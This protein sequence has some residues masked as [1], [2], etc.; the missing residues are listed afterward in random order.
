MIKY[1]HFPWTV[2]P[3]PHFF[4][5]FLNCATAPNISKS[6]IIIVSGFL[7]LGTH[8]TLRYI[9]SS[10][11]DKIKKKHYTSPA[12]PFEKYLSQYIWQFPLRKNG[13]E[14]LIS[15]VVGGGDGGGRGGG[16]GYVIVNI[17]IIIIKIIDVS[18]RCQSAP[19]TYA[20]L[21]CNV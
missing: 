16:G 10:W 6:L 19:L 11:K 5:F 17:I 2:V 12:K 18:D 7:L 9:F 15:S 14:L 4:Y 13:Y 21:L 8:L 3:L 20:Y 1:G